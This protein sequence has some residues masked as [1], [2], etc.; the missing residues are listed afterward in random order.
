MKQAW[1]KM[2]VQAYEKL[3]VSTKKEEAGW[4]G[5]CREAIPKEGKLLGKA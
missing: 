2:M 4:K 3:H 1:T 5:G